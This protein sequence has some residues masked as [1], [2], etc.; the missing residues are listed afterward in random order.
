[1]GRF[2]R[3]ETRGT[4]GRSDRTETGA[5]KTG[6]GEYPV[7]DEFGIVELFPTGTWGIPPCVI[8]AYHRFSRGKTGT[9]SRM[10]T[11]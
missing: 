9:S 4:D 8:A 3:S 1:L 5:E 10:N 2:A 6:S 7:A 11:W